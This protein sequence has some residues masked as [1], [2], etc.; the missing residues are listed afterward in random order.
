MN[1]IIPT[2]LSQLR[3]LMKQESL[4]A[5]IFPT[6]DPHN[7]EYTPEH[8]KGRQFMSG[9]SGSAGTLVV[10]Q[11]D[12]ALWTDSRYFIAARIELEG[13][14]IKLMKLK[15]P[16]TPSITEWL[17]QK[18]AHINGAQVGIDGQVNS[19]NLTEQLIADLRKQ[20]GI[21]VRTNFD[22][23]SILWTDRPK[24]P[25]NKIQIHPIEFAGETAQSKL[26]RI[27][28]HLKKLNAE[29]ILISALDDIAWTLNLRG[30]DVP[31]NPVFVAFLLLTQDDA[32]LFVDNKK[33]DDITSYLHDI[34]VETKPYDYV[35]KQ[36]K[37]YKGYNLLIDP[38]ETC[39]NLAKACKNTIIIRSKSPIPT[40]KAVKNITEINGFRNA[41]IRDGVALVK[42]QKWLTD[43]VGKSVI[44][45]MS[46]DD[47]LTSLRA[48]QKFFKGKSFD[49]ILAYGPHGAIV[50]YEATP[51]TDSQLLPEGLVLIDS[52]AQYLDGTT[53][54]TRT[55]ALGPVSQ[56]QK[57]IY[58][59]VLKGHIALANA[60]FPDGCSG[61]QIDCLARQ[62]MW[63]D[64]LN[65]L[66]G[67]G[68]GVGS[69]LNVHEG[70]HQIRMEYMPAPLK[71]GMTVTNEPGLYLEGKFGVRIENT[72]LII[73][74]NKDICKENGNDTI[75]KTDHNFLALE[76]LTLC[77]I[78]TK[79]IDLSMLTPNEIN[80][81][82]TYHQT[83]YDK[84][85]PSLEPD[86]QEWLK[87]ECAPL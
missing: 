47:K 35:N 24:I 14:H 4:D 67:T 63:K 18:L 85:A 19:L 11:S 46:A 84:L 43:N 76:Y 55:I 7:S 49:T 42:F 54:I 45:E 13:T 6:T 41:M 65:F 86:E 28:L 73:N 8:W 83:V 64:H 78:D 71:E 72:M 61:T 40:M 81:I 16:D 59:L 48:E 38:N 75:P 39:Y 87:Q 10:T 66:H 68:H 57:H 36:L 20:G 31:C 60:S 80:W 30:S 51:E 53:D 58:T 29:A 44:T 22:P 23:L 33:I 12:A 32:T 5:F 74:D 26:N 21:T 25:L 3:V 70:P 62:F 27:R 52:G 77:P 1:S 79:P 15:M 56:E 2:R 82:N 69:F 50:H 17:G 9:F 34:G 37:A